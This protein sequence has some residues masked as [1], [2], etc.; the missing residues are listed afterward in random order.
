MLLSR[1]TLSNGALSSVAVVV[2]ETPAPTCAL[3]F[4]TTE[5]A[6]NC[7]F[8]TMT[9]NIGTVNPEGKYVNATLVIIETPASTCSPLP[10]FS[11]T[12]EA[13][14]CAPTTFMKMITTTNEFGLS[15]RANLEV[16][17]TSPKSCYPTYTSINTIS[18]CSD[19]TYTTFLTTQNANGDSYAANI[20]VV[21]TGVCTAYPVTS[22]GALTTVSSTICA[23]NDSVVTSVSGETTS[24][25]YVKGIW[26]S[27]CEQ[28]STAPTLISE[29][30]PATGT[31]SLLC[32]TETLTIATTSVNLSGEV[33]YGKAVIVQTPGSSCVRATALSTTTTILADPYCGEES[34]YV[35]TSATTV[36]GVKSSIAVVVWATPDSSCQ[37][38]P[39]NTLTAMSTLTKTVM[40]TKCEHS[41]Y[42]TAFAT[43]TDGATITTTECVVNTPI[44]P[45]DINTSTVFDRTI[46]DNVTVTITTDCSTSNVISPV[47]IVTVPATANND[48]GSN[49]SSST[50][51]GPTT[52]TGAATNY[53]QA[54]GAATNYT[55]ATGTT[56]NGTQT[57]NGTQTTGKTANDT[58]LSYLSAPSGIDYTQTSI[59]GA[60]TATATTATPA[61]YEGS[62]ASIGL[63]MFLPAIAAFAFLM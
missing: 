19:N 39:V 5:A 63:N 49:N 21:E 18:S 57:D 8:T 6:R 43:V 24:I 29:T 44:S 28:Y 41:T 36:A 52:H 54:T 38:I 32:V 53:T 9:T 30:I 13:M 10:T 2:S 3:S 4:T 14:N 33:L 58:S 15:L 1:T 11:T 62:A 45:S 35:T 50:A 60:A 48:S 61:F 47:V 25:I 17:E 34:T 46:T 59:S 31:A 20:V 7:D 55:Q 27:G 26:N 42:T 37:K 56:S 23:T 51:V 22:T 16:I 12:V 40:C